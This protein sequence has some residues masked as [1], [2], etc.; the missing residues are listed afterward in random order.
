M[1]VVVAAGSTECTTGSAREALKHGEAE[2]SG[3][4]CARMT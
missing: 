4:N 3:A 2:V 1:V